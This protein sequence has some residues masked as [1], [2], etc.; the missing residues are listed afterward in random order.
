MRVYCGV[1]TGI[2]LTAFAPTAMTV[3]VTG[4]A[5]FIGSNLVRH[6]RQRWPSRRIVSFDALTYAGNPENLASLADDPLH[7]FVRGDV[8]D[9]EAVARVFEAWDVTGVMHL[10]A[11]SHVD[12]S[13]VGPMDFVTTNVVGTATLL[14]AAREAWAG[15]TDARFLHVSTDEVFGS[16][17]AT[18]AFDERTPYDP[19][20]PYSS[21]KA[22]SDHLVRAWGH[23]YGL[24]VLITN[25]TNNYGPWQFPEKLVPVVITRAVEGTPVPIYGDGLQVRDWLHVEDHCEA[26]ALVFE[27]GAVGHTYC[28]GG[29]SEVTNLS[30][31]HQLL[32]AVD[33][34][35]ERPV[36]AS[37]QL[38][39]HVTDRPGHDRRYAMDIAHIRSTLG[40]S[41]RWR[42]A[43][44]LAATVSWYLANQAWAARARSGEHRA[45]ESL[46]YDARGTYDPNTQENG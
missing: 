38:I 36:G 26:L 35:L 23:T 46:W 4:A 24:P 41:P 13:I 31:V 19:R 9:A 45:F 15:R 42:L 39:H 40:W 1:P 6:L 10:A 7:T 25:C 28:I 16:L 8:R 3:L 22:A 44:G 14:H 34:T 12:R 17:G 11:E 29:E 2:P 43:D 27:Q 21:S 5:G 20:S 33:A 30:L 37:R 32:D 18:G